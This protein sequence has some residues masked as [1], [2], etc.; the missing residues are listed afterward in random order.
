[1]S[2]QQDLERIAETVRNEGVV[3]EPPSAGLGDWLAAVFSRA[4]N[5]LDSLMPSTLGLGGLGTVLVW[6]LVAI[7]V[8]GVCLLVVST[9]S[10]RRKTVP[11]EHFDELIDRPHA[12]SR[13]W[14]RALRAAIDRGD[15]SAAVEACWWRLVLE[16]GPAE[17]H[18]NLK[19]DPAEA[20]GTTGRRAV[21]S[22]GR[23]DLMPLVH[24]LEAITYGR[25][26]LTQAGVENVAAKIEATFS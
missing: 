21:R 18:P 22:A 8:F 10:R 17:E 9:L 19:P 6:A 2:R 13:D 11:P 14:R 25:T 20:R 5:W 15:L 1:M 4:M 23:L 26:P 3:L 12:D 24:Q 7:V 16:V